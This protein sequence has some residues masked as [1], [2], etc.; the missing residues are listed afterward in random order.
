MNYLNE[1]DIKE[2]YSFNAD[3]LLSSLQSAK[4]K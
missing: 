3:Y 4:K 1:K 2:L